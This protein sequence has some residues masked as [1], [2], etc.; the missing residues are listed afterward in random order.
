M[1]QKNKTKLEK[2][3]PLKIRAEM[4]RKLLPDA[5]KTTEEL[6]V[7]RLVATNPVDMVEL[8]FETDD[9]T[10]GKVAEIGLDLI[11]TDKTKLFGYAIVRAITE[12]WEKS[13]KRKPKN[14]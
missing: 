8:T 1:K 11:K 2:K 7:I 14:D 12:V 4:D 10:L 3:A 13:V 9:E 5:Q 6:G